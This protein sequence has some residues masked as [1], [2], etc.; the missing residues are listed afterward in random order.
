MRIFP[1]WNAASIDCIQT[2][3]RARALFKDAA[4]M[5][6]AEHVLDFL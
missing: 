5:K 1:I 4:V 3:D 2:V 6:P